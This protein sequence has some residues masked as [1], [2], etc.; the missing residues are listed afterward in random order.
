MIDVN[1]LGSISGAVTTTVTDSAISGASEV[2]F[3]GGLESLIFSNPTSQLQING[4]DEVDIINIVSVD[5]ALTTVIRID[6]RGG[7]DVVDGSGATTDLDVQGGNG[8]D[9]LTGGSGDDLINGN[10]GDDVLRRWK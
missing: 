7:D 4:T 1:P 5:A 3:S 9:I 8:N 6:S 2:T 10:A